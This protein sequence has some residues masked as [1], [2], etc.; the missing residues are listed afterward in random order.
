M[1]R[2][3]SL[4]P[5]IPFPHCIIIV[6]VVVIILHFWA[7]IW[8][9]LIPEK[10]RAQQKERASQWVP[11]WCFH[12]VCLNENII[13]IKLCF[14]E[15]P[16]PVLLI[17]REREKKVGILAF[18]ETLFFYCYFV[19][20]KQPKDSWFE[21]NV[22]IWLQWQMRQCEWFNLALVKIFDSKS[23]NTNM[24]G[25]RFLYGYFSC[26]KMIHTR[27]SIWEIII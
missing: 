18:I 17:L 2:A 10:H 4:I 3:S 14:I 20:K 19:A 27:Y 22:W 7:A 24:R 21:A 1:C 15:S 5:S 6:I 8:V 23:I 12:R 26:L 16:F 11:K 9:G 13:F 25:Q